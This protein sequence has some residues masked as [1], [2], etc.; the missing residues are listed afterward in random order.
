MN[1]AI[2]GANGFVGSNLIKHFVAS[3]H[4]VTALVR[5]GSSLTLLPEG[6]HIVPLDYHDQDAIL[7]ALQQIDVLVHNA[8]KTKALNHEEMLKANL[9]TTETLVRTIN[10]LDNPLHLIYISSQAASRPSRN[11]R[12]INEEEP[13]APVTSYGKS[14][15]AAE[16]CVRNICQQPWT[17]VR[18]C[19][20]YGCGD[21]DFLTLFKLAKRG[22]AFRIGHQDR[23]LNMIH[24]SELA[25]FIGLCAANP[26]A[27]N[28]VFFATDGLIYR[29]SQV[30]EAIAAS[31]GKA[32]H[33]VTVPESLT[34]LVFRVGDLYG[35]LL[36]KETIINKEKLNEILADSW[37]ADTSKAARLL[38]WQPE[39]NL[40][41]H[42]MDTKTC[43]EEL[44]WL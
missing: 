24:V 30:T 12:P 35:R 6:S 2:T 29:Q 37:L 19:S 25:A 17:V 32:T 1:I 43:Y 31:L 42:I 36:K 21:K 14:K 33:L 7:D 13:C 10:Q 39:A 9:G 4:H 11:N 18:P 15:L 3:G 27:Y 34:S 38:G 8:G 26:R 5:P 40:T 20:I 22:F 44:G 41:K 23:L 16:K 28:Q